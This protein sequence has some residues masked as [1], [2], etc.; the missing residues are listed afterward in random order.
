MRQ[1]EVDDGGSKGGSY[2]IYFL[3]L[4]HL[5]YLFVYFYLLNLSLH[6]IL[7][8]FFIPS[9][10]PSCLDIILLT[11]ITLTSSGQ[12]HL[13][14]FMRARGLAGSSAMHRLTADVED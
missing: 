2:L 10:S 1:D 6:R 13:S 3:D 4:S 14:Y 8:I 11:S 5:S 7:T 12:Q 9:I